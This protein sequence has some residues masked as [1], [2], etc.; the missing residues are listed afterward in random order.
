ME[1]SYGDT[2]PMC[3]ECE[4]MMND[5]S[6]PQ[7][8]LFVC[9]RCNGTPDGVEV[10]WCEFECGEPL[11]SNGDCRG[12]CRGCADCGNL[13]VDDDGSLCADCQAEVDEGDECDSCGEMAMHGGVCD[14]CGY[15][16]WDEENDDDE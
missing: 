15:D 7:D 3:T 14:N 13:I 8:P 11:N 2:I 1:N 10:E 16:K 12:G 6:K 9:P 5:Y 4:V